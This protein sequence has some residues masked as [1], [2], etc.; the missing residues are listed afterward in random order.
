MYQRKQT[1]ACRRCNYITFSV[2]NLLDIYD[3]TF[4]SLC[5]NVWEW[6]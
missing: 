3:Y 1:M 5:F 2:V 4:S 6:L